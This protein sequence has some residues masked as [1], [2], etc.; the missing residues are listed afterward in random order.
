MKA[1]TLPSHEMFDT[2]QMAAE[3]NPTSAA[4]AASTEAVRGHRRM[5][6]EQ[7][8]ALETIGHAVDYLLDTHIHET[9]AGQD[10]VSECNAEIEAICILTHSRNVLLQS[11]PLQAPL[12]SR[13][14]RALEN[15]VVRRRTGP[16]Y[17]PT[18]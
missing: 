4:L 2:Q 3:P 12:S 17:P 1:Q 9:G 5:S 18:V 10:I 7:G 14:W 13:I 11:L 6:R 8:H 16:L 15:C